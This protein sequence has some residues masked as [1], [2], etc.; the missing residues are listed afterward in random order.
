[1]HKGKRGKQPRPDVC[2]CVGG[3]GGGGGG[4]GAMLSRSVRALTRILKTGVPELSIPKSGSP[5]IQKNTKIGVPAQ[6]WEFRTAYQQLV[7]ALISVFI[8]S[9]YS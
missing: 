1:M 7:R 6:K 3:G 8:Y 9:A 2:V 5:T 4:R